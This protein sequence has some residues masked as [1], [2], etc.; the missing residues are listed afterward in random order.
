MKYM[1]ESDGLIDLRLP[2]THNSG[3]SKMRQYR[4]QLQA[5]G[6]ASGL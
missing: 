1:L 6:A 3:A 5:G 2:K 4:S